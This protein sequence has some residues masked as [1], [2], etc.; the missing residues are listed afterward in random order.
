MRYPA[1]IRAERRI[2]NHHS[3][4]W[5]GPQSPTT[6]CPDQRVASCRFRRRYDSRRCRAERWKSDRF[7]RPEYHLGA[8]RD[9]P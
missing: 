3:D 4:R 6:E 9:A 2:V 8:A 5:N 7:A 1:R